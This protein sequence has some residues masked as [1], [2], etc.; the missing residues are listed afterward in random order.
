MIVLRKIA[1]GVKSL[2]LVIEQSLMI[3]S[4]TEV[5]K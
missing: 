3:I 5:L 1:K 4:K 2:E